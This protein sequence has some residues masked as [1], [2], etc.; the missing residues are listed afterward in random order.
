MD[1]AIANNDMV[2][3]HVSHDLIEVAT[4]KLEESGTAT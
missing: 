2:G 1:E 4:K 3:I